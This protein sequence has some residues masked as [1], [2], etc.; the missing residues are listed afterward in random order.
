MGKLMAS[1]KKAKEKSKDG[2][3]KEADFDVLYSTGFLTLDHLNGTMVHVDAN[4]IK[5]DYKS[6]GIVD[7]SSN[8]FIGRSGCGKSTIVTQIIGNLMKQFPE[9]DAYI[10]D[11]EGSLPF[12][13]KEFLLGLT[14]EDLHDRVLI[15]NNEINTENVYAQIKEIHDLKLA[16]RAD[17]EYDT[18]LYDTYGHRITKLIPTFYFIDSFAMLMPKELSEADELDNG[19]GAT[20]TA[21]KNTQ[22]IKKISQLLKGANII[23]FT[24]N[25][26]LDDIQMGFL[27]KPVQIDGLKQGERLP[28]GKAAIYLANNLIR[29]DEKTKLKDTEGFGINGTIIDATLVKS[30]TNA[31]RRSVPLIF[32][33]TNGCFD[34]ILSI[35]QFL[36]AEGAVGGAGRSLYLENA[37]DLKFSQKEFKEKLMTNPELQKAFA[38][39]AKE[40][41]DKLLS[42]TSNKESEA[43][44]VDI[45]SMILIA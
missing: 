34:N 14:G 29:L 20:A 22:I 35:Y 40:Y 45:N 16:N 6:V 28:G 25:H 36:K 19:M 27:P 26:I 38:Q 42:D 37:P 12:V 21:K 18:G 23:L 41:L 2:T 30:R 1:Y 13:R 39:I 5:T 7:G 32:D 10:D 11:I 24:V 33:K 3:G 44:V 9:S 15:R 8:T 43:E 31:T 17:Y 4:G